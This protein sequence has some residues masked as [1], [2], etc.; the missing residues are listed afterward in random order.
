MH[1][2][3]IIIAGT[4][5]SRRQFLKYSLL[6]AAGSLAFTKFLPVAQAQV[7]GSIPPTNYLLLDDEACSVGELCDNT[8]VNIRMGFR[9]SLE[10]TF[11]LDLE[12]ITPG[13]TRIAPKSEN[14]EISGDCGLQHNG[15]QVYSGGSFSVTESITNNPG[16]ISPGRYQIFARPGGTNPNIQ[17][18]L[19][20]DFC[21][22]ANGNTQNFAFSNLDPVD[23][24]S[25]NVS[26][27]GSASI[28]I[29]NL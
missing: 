2:N 23:I 17:V 25:I 12:V 22:Q 11:D 15:D 29:F 16:K 9:E 28:R 27:G 8:N 19:S 18:S 13:G 5:H 3:K 10:N 21:G 24:G 14:G 26:N 7:A 6:G 20:A 1:K 4:A